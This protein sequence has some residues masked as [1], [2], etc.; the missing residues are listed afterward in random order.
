MSEEIKVEVEE[1]EAHQTNID[2]VRPS[3][4]TRNTDTQNVDNKIPYDRFKAKVDEANRLK[5]E[6]AA[7]KKAQEEAERKK[8]EEQNEYKKLYEKAL[9]D[10]E[11]FKS[12][13]LSAKK[14]ALLVQ[15][16][17]SSDQAN[18]LHNTVQGE[19]DEELAK[20]IEELKSVIAP[21]PSYVDPLPMNGERSKPEPKDPSEI[22]LKTFER[23]KTKLFQGEMK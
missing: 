21:K 1:K 7:L 22:G 11:A 23:I 12:E 17:Y 6:L 13:A 2:D 18:V 15:A 14:K 10:L 4:E 3:D 8:L 16:G 20:S 9:N 5:E 19:T